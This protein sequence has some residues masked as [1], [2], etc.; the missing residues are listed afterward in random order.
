M[1]LKS[2]IA[3]LPVLARW[4]AVVLAAVLLVPETFS[5]EP[6]TQQQIL[7]KLSPVPEHPR[8]FWTRQE[9]AS[10]R[11]KLNSDAQLKAVW[12]GVRLTADHMLQEPVVAYRKDGRRLLGRSR[13]ALGRMMH[14]GFA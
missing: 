11:A 13:E 10:V 3:Y 5:A 9:E 6:P 4:P 8:L 7:Q 14:L 1:P 12:E 2:L